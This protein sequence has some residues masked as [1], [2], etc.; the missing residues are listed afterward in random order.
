MLQEFYVSPVLRTLHLDAGLQVR[1]HQCRVEGQDHL[2]QLAG[3]TSSDAAQDTVGLLGCE[4]TLLTHVQLP[5]HQ[6]S[7]VLFMRDVTEFSRSPKVQVNKTLISSTFL[8]AIKK[9]ES[10]L[11]LNVLRRTLEHQLNL[12][13]F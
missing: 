3:H 5:I 12:N 9:L 8:G 6:C 7:Q 13:R 1:S 4:G 2:P 10:G 11:N